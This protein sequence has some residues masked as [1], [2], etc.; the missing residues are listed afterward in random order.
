[1]L[2][3]APDVELDDARALDALVFTAV[4]STSNA[5]QPASNSA[6]ISAEQP[7]TSSAAHSVGAPS[8]SNPENSVAQPVGCASEAED[9]GDNSAGETTE[10]VNLDITTL[11]N[12]TSLHDD[13]LR[14]GACLAHVVRVPRPTKARI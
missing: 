7:A 2:S 5:A 13:L 4:A 9:I 10:D 11:T 1:M 3:D 12:A 14:R 6:A 8:S